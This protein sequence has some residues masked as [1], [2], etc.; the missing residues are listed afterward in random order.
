MGHPSDL[1]MGHPSDLGL[2]HPSD[3]GMGRLSDLGLGHP[4]DLGMGRPSDPSY[5]S[6]VYVVQGKH[7][8]VY[9]VVSMSGRVEKLGSRGVL[10]SYRD[11]SSRFFFSRFSFGGWGNTWCS[12]VEKSWLLLVTP[13]QGWYKS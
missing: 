2:G 8:L 5:V 9:C 11:S 10:S 13:N 4:S 1:G 6:C 3:L 7:S 12:L